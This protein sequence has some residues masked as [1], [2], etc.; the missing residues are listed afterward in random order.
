MF[1]TTLG[2]SVSAALVMLAQPAAADPDSHSAS[3]V[4]TVRYVDADNGNSMQYI[5]NY[6]KKFNIAR[7][8]V[9]VEYTDGDAGVSELVSGSFGADLYAPF[10]SVLSPRVELG[11]GWHE[12]SDN[13]AFY[14]MGATWSKDFGSVTAD[15]SF[16]HRSNFDDP[17]GNSSANRWGIGLGTDLGPGVLSV[18][19]YTTDSSIDSQ[20]IGLSYSIS[21]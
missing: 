15:L 10:D 12:N 21:L 3:L 13:A 7:V 20:S 5:E 1:K 8:G 4:S 6:N 9:E 2:L 18:H 14:G 17:S 11:Y 16:R 19:Y